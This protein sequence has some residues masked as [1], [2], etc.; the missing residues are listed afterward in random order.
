MDQLLPWAELIAVVEP[1]YPKSSEL[2][3]RRRYR[4]SGW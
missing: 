2:G 1:F 4:W 3:G